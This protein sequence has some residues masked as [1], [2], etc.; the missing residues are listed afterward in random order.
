MSSATAI[1]PSP[2]CTLAV[3][4]V[5]QKAFIRRIVTRSGVVARDV[6]DVV[7]NAFLQI[8]GALDRFDP[9]GSLRAWLATIARRTA[10]A[11]LELRR[12]MEAPLGIDGWMREP[13]ACR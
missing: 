4:Y 8:A 2:A 10:R 12:T 11:H 6:E 13:G 9:K 1:A 7:H 3:L 5:E